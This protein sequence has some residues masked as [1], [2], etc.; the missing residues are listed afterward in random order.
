VIILDTDVVLIDYRYPRDPRFQRNRQALDRLRQTAEPLGITTQ[1]LLE[2]VGV[3]SFNVTA[4]FIEQLP[5]A[6]QT[7]YGLTLFPNPSAIP[8]FAGCSFDEIVYQMKQK[9][10][11]GDAI[12]AVLVRKFAPPGSTLLT[13]N[14]KHFRGKLTVPVFTPEEWLQQQPHAGPNPP[15]GPTP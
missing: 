8:D 12:Q 3:L 10:G 13:W 11:L 7:Q 6:I 1:A 15:T 9:M 5:N 4:T 2:V 14:A